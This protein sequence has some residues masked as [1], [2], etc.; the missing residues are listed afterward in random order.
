MIIVI[1]TVEVANGKREEFLSH[2]RELVPKVEEEEGCLEYGPTVD[3]TTNIAAQVEMR[4]SI[5]TIVERWEDLE[6]L[7]MHLV[8]P[9]MLEY[10]GKVKD[11]V[12]NVSLQVLEPAE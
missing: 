7:E 12:K 4:P 6:A 8:A 10:R 5:V 2:F 3:V 1:A 11:L 9:H